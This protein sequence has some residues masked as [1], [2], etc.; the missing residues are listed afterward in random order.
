MAAVDPQ[1]SLDVRCPDVSRSACGEANAQDGHPGPA[2]WI[3]TRGEALAR[4]SVAKAR[5]DTRGCPLARISTGAFKG[6]MARSEGGSPNWSSPVPRVNIA[7]E[8]P[9]VGFTGVHYHR[10]DHYVYIGGVHGE[11]KATLYKPDSQQLESELLWASYVD[12]HAAGAAT[13]YRVIVIAI[14]FTNSGMLVRSPTAMST[15]RLSMHLFH[16]SGDHSSQGPLPREL[17]CGTRSTRSRRSRFSRQGSRRGTSDTCPL[18]QLLCISSG[19]ALSLTG[20][21]V[22]SISC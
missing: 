14:G 19:A 20:S 5:I 11:A 12:S 2:A 6:T 3:D 1:S 10:V 15:R 7:D 18:G 9:A 4:V 13:A 8:A 17:H 21:R 16:E 22:A